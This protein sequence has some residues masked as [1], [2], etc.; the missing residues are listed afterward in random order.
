MVYRLS[1]AIVGTFAGDL[2]RIHNTI[3]FQHW[4]T[5]EI[6]A[7]RLDG[8][9][10]YSK[11]RLSHIALVEGRIAALNLAYERPAGGPAYPEDCIY[12]HRFAVAPELRNRWLGRLFHAHAVDA[13]FRHVPQFLNRTRPQVYGQTQAT[14]EN[15]HVLRF[16]LDGCGFRP[17]GF[18]YYPEKVDVVI[19]LS[20]R[21]FYRS[22]HW[23][24]LRRR[25]SR[26]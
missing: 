9:V 16:Y 17:V 19:R 6:G 4:T 13:A 8:R 5:K 23:Q 21:A 3:P 15:A 20:R 22:P 25:R 18:V 11:W 10:F 1:R 2:V 14:L 26:G 7:D 12:M 24:E